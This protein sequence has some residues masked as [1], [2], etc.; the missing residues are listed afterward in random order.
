MLSFDKLDFFGWP[1]L[2]VIPASATC[3]LTPSASGLAGVPSPPPLARLL[4]SRSLRAPQ[5]E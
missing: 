3:A 5:R 1:S 4:L 2:Y